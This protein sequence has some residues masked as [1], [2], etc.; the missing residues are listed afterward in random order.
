MTDLA[1]LAGEVRLT[2]VVLA[3]RS[4]AEQRG[5]G[6]G[7]VDEAGRLRRD[8]V[9]A[10][11]LAGDH[12]GRPGLDDAEGSVLA[13]V[14]ALVLPVVG[15]GV[16][17]A[18]IGGSGCVEE[19]RGVVVRERIGVLGPVGVGVLPLVGEGA[20]PVGGGV[21]E[22]VLARH[23]DRLV[24]VGAG[25]GPAEGHATVVAEGL[26]ATVVV[27]A[28][29]HVDDRLEIGGEEDLEGVLGLGLDLGH[30]RRVRSPP[31]S[32]GG[33]RAAGPRRVD[34]RELGLFEGIKV[35]QYRQAC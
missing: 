7:D 31:P 8:P 17:H 16:E 32:P 25:S 30:G 9:V 28:D 18:E 11:A 22:G 33:G 34:R 5:H 2:P 10:D 13:Q 14:T 35:T 12:P 3:D 19:L 1:V 26:V 20:E 6:G 4:A 24:A 23:R 15:R 27:V 29:H 21:G